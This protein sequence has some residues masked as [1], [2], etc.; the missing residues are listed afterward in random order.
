MKFKKVNLSNLVINFP[1]LATVGSQVQVTPDTQK[2]QMLGI[3]S[4]NGY[5]FWLEK[6]GA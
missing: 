4:A 3:T 6:L 5:V 2:L 1:S